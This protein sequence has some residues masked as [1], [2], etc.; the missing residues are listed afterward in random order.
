MGNAGARGY[1]RTAIAP[2]VTRK[3]AR[4]IA[5]LS[6]EERMVALSDEWEQVRAGR[7]DVGTVLDLAGGF[8]SERTA[9]VMQTLTSILAAVGEDATTDATRGPHIAAGS[10]RCSRRRWRRS[11]R[12]LVR[13]I[14]TTSGVCARR[15][16]P[17]LAARLTTRPPCRRRATSC[18]ASSTSRGPSSRRS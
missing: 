15:S 11:G 7:H 16:C 5:T 6:P 12:P 10:R 3:L 9:T 1:Y 14:P 4:D 17:P 2:E 13:P 8:A 18:A